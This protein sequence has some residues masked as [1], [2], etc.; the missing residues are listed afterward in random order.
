[1]CFKFDILGYILN[2]DPDSRPDI[3]QVSYVAFKLRGLECPVANTKVCLVI[4]YFLAS[5]L[6]VLVVANL[7]AKVTSFYFLSKTWIQ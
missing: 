1:M 3:F 7:D 2:P 5:A 4:S 6:V